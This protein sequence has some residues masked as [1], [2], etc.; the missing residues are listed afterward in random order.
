MKNYFKAIFAYLNSLVIYFT[1]LIGKTSREAA[2]LCLMMLFDMLTGLF[3]AF[4]KKSGKSEGGGFASKH[5]YYGILKKLLILVMLALSSLVDEYF[6]LNGLIKSLAFGFY[7]TSEALS[8]IENAAQIG[9]PFPKGI[10][11]MLEVLKDKSDNAENETGNASMGGNE[12]ENK[13]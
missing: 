12:G 4:V 11:G 8:I 10:R 5:L 1:G 3:L 6:K 9:V 2:I 7:L 13:G